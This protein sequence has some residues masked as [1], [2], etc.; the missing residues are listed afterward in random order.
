MAN[1]HQT[2]SRPHFAD[3]PSLTQRKTPPVQPDASSAATSA[4]GS[5]KTIAGTM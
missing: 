5:R 4:W 3:I 1:W 2:A